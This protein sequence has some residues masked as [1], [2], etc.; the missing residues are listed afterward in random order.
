[1][2]STR[3]NDAQNVPCLHVVAPPAGGGVIYK[4]GRAFKFT[5]PLRPKILFLNFINLKG[6]HSSEHVQ[7]TIPIG[8]GNWPP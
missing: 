8:R 6:L 7:G 2:W 3:K 1:M 4:D 5:L